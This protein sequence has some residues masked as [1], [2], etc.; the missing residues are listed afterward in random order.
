MSTEAEWEQQAKALLKA[1]RAEINKGYIWNPKEFASGRQILD[2]EPRLQIHLVFVLFDPKRHD[3]RLNDLQTALLARSLPY[4][5]TDIENLLTLSLSRGYYNGRFPSVLRQVSRFIKQGNELTPAMRKALKGIKEWTATINITEARKIAVQIVEL[6]GEPI[7]VQPDAGESWADAALADLATFSSEAQGAWKRVFAHAQTAES[8]KPNAAWRKEANACVTA[9]GETAFREAI[10]RW[11]QAVTLPPIKT[12]RSE[13]GG[14]VYESHASGGSDRNISLLKGLAWMC[15]DRKEPEVARALG[16][17]IE[18]SLKKIPGLGPWAVRASNGAIWALSEMESA[19]AVAQLGRLKTKVTFRTAL[20]QIEKGLETAARRAGVTKADLEDLAVPTYGFDEKGV[21][22]EGLGECATV[23]IVTPTGDIAVEWFAANGK[24][25]KSVPAEAKKDY[26]EEV[27]A[28]KADV[29]AAGKMLTAQK[30]RFDSFYLPER[31]WKLQTWRE[32]F[33]EHP[34]LGNIARRLIWQFTTG[35]RTEA[36]IWNAAQNGF[37]SAAG[38]PLDWLSDATE[39]RLWHPIGSDADAVLAWR[40]YV[41]EHEIVQPFKQAY[42]EVYLLTEAELR[43]R[44]YSNRFAGHILKQH[45]MNSLAALRGWRNKLRLMVDDD[46]PPASK[47]LPEYGLRA[48]FWIEGAGD[49]YGAD[50]TDTGTY[51]YLTTDQVRFYRSDAPENYAH[52]SGG[53]YAMEHWRP[54]APAEPLPLEEVPVLV[55]SEIMRDVDLFVGVTS[56]GNDPTWQDGGPQGR[57]QN[58]WT[59]YSFGE[60]SATAQTRRAVLERLLP[61]LKIAARCS[62]VDKFLVVRG[63]LRTYKIHLGSGNILMEPNDQ[64]LCIVQDRSASKGEN[65]T[66]LPFEG[67]QRLSLILS[68]AFLLADDKKITDV[69]ITRQILPQR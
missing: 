8:A 13:Y 24:P 58:Y 52:A 19:E 42:R 14:E 31:A 59:D 25:V 48:E 39:V 56:V 20:N 68:K 36:G 47:E 22:R 66:F 30:Q 6:V 2:A 35:E 65:T 64:Y 21:R 18:A 7:S 16:K 29:D 34:I 43:T 15:A 9:V 55:F 69:T 53:G 33:S 3:W 28:F 57:Y 5:Q 40:N 41:Q 12:N 63:D 11:F 67:D 32:R 44:T 51:L 46:Y 50:T 37:V 60:L 45:Q 27:K 62:L 26:A 49:N 54:D 17:L 61:R 4:T 10:C 38:Q 1:F 23:A